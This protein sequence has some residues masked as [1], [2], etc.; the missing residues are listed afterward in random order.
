[1]INVSN[2]SFS[3]P[4]NRG[5]FNLNFTVS[6]GEV[7]GYLGPN[8]AGKTTTMR[9]LLGFTPPDKGTCQINNL[10]CFL[11]APQIQQNL[12]Y[13]PGEI[14]F[15]DK[16]TGLGFLSLMHEL[17]GTKD[18]HREK[19]L[20]ERFELNPTGPIRRFSKGM[21]QKL[22]IIAAFMHDPAVL[23]LDEPTSGLDPLMQN[24]FIE[25]VQEEKA[26]SKTIIMS[27]HQFDEVEKT[28]DRVLVIKD[29]HIVADNSITKLKSLQKKVYLLNLSRPEEITKLPKKYSATRLDSTHYEVAVLGGK[30]NAFLKDIRLLKLDNLQSKVQSLEEIFL[31]YYGQNTAQ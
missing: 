14:N 26:R 12:G 18:R 28:S 9:C 20:I 29:G 16:M 6:P 2:L 19:Q 23:L 22:G 10:D 25:M 31:N 8:G 27:S 30:I 1:M 13:I 7:V 11:C 24:R 5:I 21:K 4:N 3:Y 17:R 15:F